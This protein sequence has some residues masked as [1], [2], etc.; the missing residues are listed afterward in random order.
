MGVCFLFNNAVMFVLLFGKIA[1]L[2]LSSI[3]W[4]EETKDSIILVTCLRKDKT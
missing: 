2:L 4:V 1:K 3:T